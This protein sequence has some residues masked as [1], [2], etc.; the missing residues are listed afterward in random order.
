M[1]KKALRTTLSV[2]LFLGTLVGFQYGAV[3][4][5]VAAVATCAQGGTCSVGDVGPG[6]GKV[7]YASVGTFNCGQNFAQ[8][9][10]YLEA[11]PKTWSGSGSDPNYFWQLGSLQTV[12]ISN[13]SDETVPNN[14]D[15]AIGLG[16]RN[17]IN[18]VNSG[19]GAN[20]AAG[21]ARA[22]L[23]GGKSDWY[24]PNN[25]EMNLL[26]QWARGVIQNVATV[27][28]GGSSNSDFVNRDYWTSSEFN[29]SIAWRTWMS[30]G[31][32]TPGEKNLVDS[33]YAVRP[34]R[35]FS[36]SCAG[37]GTCIVGDTGPG[38]GTVYYVAPSTFACGP[39]LA[40]TCK[41]LEAAPQN[42]NTYIPEPSSVWSTITTGSI[43]AGGTAIGTGFKN[44]LAIISKG[45]GTSPA[46]ERVR[47]YQGVGPVP[48]SDWYMASIDEIQV[49]FQSV[50]SL[51][52]YSYTYASSS[53]EWDSTF[54]RYNILYY[55]QGGGGNRSS[56]PKVSSGSPIM[57]VVKPVRA[58]SA[59]ELTYTPRTINFSEASIAASY[60]ITDPA[61]TLIANVSAGSGLATFTSST[62]GVC[63]INSSSGTVLFVSA[64]SCTVSAS[65]PSDY[66]FAA[67]TTTKTFQVSKLA[68][69]IGF[70]L[71]NPTATYRQPITITLN[72]E[73]AG[74]IS[75][76][77]NG[78]AVNGCINIAILVSRSCTF[79]PSSHGQVSLVVLFKP[80]DSASYLP[81]SS[82]V[83]NI[84]VLARTGYR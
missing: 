23:G 64:G 47:A 9:C 68:S 81:T 14:S 10:N 44:T 34:V 74:K 19:N 71:S 49:M 38:G 55:S 15:A 61:P 22:Y 83:F 51:G 50:G 32:Q 7:F 35:A 65:I 67:A 57:V 70:S 73:T 48:V 79:K 84:P 20:S 82:T 3:S 56:F 16:Y 52:F 17:S 13:I 24:L 76:R 21:A 42:W 8:L 58:F 37:G 45:A 59:T 72:S 33:N 1:H 77:A 46:G 60:F 18:I 54:N 36:R 12:N 5:A 41:Y 63:T 43:S 27:C 6:G 2:V 40:I 80:N 69:T 28:S 62:P 53:E 78:K 66:N 26:C 75:L 39:T 29:G 25:A 30:A 4:Q 11:A 31:N